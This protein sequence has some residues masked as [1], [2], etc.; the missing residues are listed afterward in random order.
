M[1]PEERAK[2]FLKLSRFTGVEVTSQFL[3]QTE[4]HFP[5]AEI[6]C[7][8]NLIEGIYK[9]AGDSYALCIWSRSAVGQD[10]EI[11]HDVFSPQSDGSWTMQYA[12]KKGNLDGA[13]NRSLFAAQTYCRWRKEYGG[14]RVDQA[15]RLKELEKEKTRLK[16]L[17]AD[18]SL[19]NDILKEAVR[20]NF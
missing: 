3:R 13:V 18:L 6:H 14:M 2:L 1:N 8:H 12:A 17:V 16:K 9:P 7:L 19:D 20:G 11:Y 10:R 15:K 5:Q 4:E